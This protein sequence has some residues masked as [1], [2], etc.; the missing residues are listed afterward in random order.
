MTDFS[1]FAFAAGTVSATLV[2]IKRYIGVAPVSVLAV[3]PNKAELEKLYNTQLEK[4][5]EYITEVENNGKAFKNVRIDFIIKTTPE[6]GVDITTKA[7]FFIRNQYRVNRDETKVQVIDKYGRTCWMTKEQFKAHEIPTYKNGNPANIDKDYRP[8]YVGEEELTSFIK[9]YLGIPNVMKYVNNTWVLVDNPQD[10]EARLDKIENYFK[11]DF[12]ELKSAIAL[13]PSNM[14]KVMFGV[15]TTDD[16]RQ[17]Q[18]VYTQM[19]LKV[20]VTDYSKLDKDLQERKANGAY[21][22]VEFLADN[23]KEY[24]VEPTN[25]NTVQNDMPFNEDVSSPF[26]F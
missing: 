11:G 24:V 3:N 15:K 18:T 14:V 1:F 21:S 13:Q 7:S 26:D 2:E 8:C 20:G 10:S 4:A 17:Y 16:N 5:P 9:N 6:S 23:I 22:N 12:S 19:T 25:L